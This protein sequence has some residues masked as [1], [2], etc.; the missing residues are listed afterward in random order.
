MRI[1]PS[2]SLKF[3]D[4]PRSYQFQYIEGYRQEITNSNL[5]FGTTMH[6][7]IEEY[8]K[9]LTLTGREIDI[10]E[11]F[12]EKWTD[13]RNTMSV[14]YNATM[15]YDDLKD[16]GLSL[17]SQ[18]PEAWKKSGLIVLLEQSGKPCLELKVVVEVQ[19]ITLSM[20]LDA[21]CMNMD[22]EIVVIDFKTPATATGYELARASD[23]LTAYQIGCEQI[24]ESLGIEE[25]HSVGF[26]E[27]V[28][29]KVSK[30]GRG[31]GPV[32]EPPLLIPAKSEQEKGEY[33][34]KL[35]W[36]RDDIDRGRFPKRSRMSYNSPC[37]MCDYRGLCQDGNVAGLSKRE[38]K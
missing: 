2:A 18:F 14:S 1:S 24:A 35:Q 8:L 29:K 20:K 31:K 3:D 5:I 25:V 9:E 34:H 26:F 6:A 15:G 33:I 16:T 30:T 23:Q 21:L 38:K 32:I 12:D 19:G 36:M 22:G 10:M 11:V 37:S 28:K 13:V 17:C 27:L 4:C 7:C